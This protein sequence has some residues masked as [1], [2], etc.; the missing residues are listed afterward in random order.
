MKRI[1]LL[2]FLFF[3]SFNLTQA[4]IHLFKKKCTPRIAFYNVEN[5]FDTIDDP[6]KPDDDFT[7]EGRQQWSKARYFAKLLKI[8]KV[9]KGME[10]PAFI[11]MCEVENQDVLEDLVRRPS[12]QNRAYGIVHHESPDYRGIDVALLYDKKQFKVQKSQTIRINFPADIVEDYTTRD[13][14]MVE[15][16]F[17]K[18]QSLYFF[19][20]HWPS[21]RGGL[22][23]SEPKRT[24]VAQ[25]LREAVDSLFSINPNAQIIIM[26]DFND[27]TDNKSIAE[28]LNAQT[29]DSSIAS[30]MLYNCFAKFDQAKQG[31]YNFR[32]NMNMLDQIIVSST[33]MQDGNLSVSNP[34]IF[35]QD[36]MIYK[37]KRYGDAPN[38]TFGGPNYYGGT[39][40]HF[41]VY[42]DLILK[43]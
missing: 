5:L 33:L 10:H 26:G 28:T 7:P 3:L 8:G 31:S 42:V 30:Q 32:G 12:L 35:K 34:T 29:D 1:A 16:T 21:R 6:E 17:Q 36:W 15:G 14:L 20:N 23:E 43:K 19:V 18:N 39:S 9:I 2:S 24:Y 13:I 11:G 37:G 22:K 40:D 38:R 27:E 25:Q 41:P 4:Q